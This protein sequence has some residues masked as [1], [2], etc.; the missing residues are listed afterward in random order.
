MSRRLLHRFQNPKQQV[1]DSIEA[2]IY[3]RQ[4]IL[5]SASRSG[6]F[7]FVYHAHCCFPFLPL[8]IAAG[9][10]DV[11]ALAGAVLVLLLVGP[12]PPSKFPSRQGI[13]E[14]HPSIDPPVLVGDLILCRWRASSSPGSIFVHASYSKLVLIAIL[15]R[16]IIEGFSAMF[17]FRHVPLKG[18][19]LNEITIV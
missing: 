4:V 8:A 1:C 10:L 9:D 2:L 14:L 3:F 5:R 7:H 12:K 18:N 13:R 16:S 11:P 6:L 17:S 15:R 19:W